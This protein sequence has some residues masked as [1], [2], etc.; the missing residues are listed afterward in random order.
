MML[1]HKEIGDKE[2]KKIINA[3]IDDLFL[4]PFS[5]EKI[6]LHLKKGLRQRK[7]ILHERQIEK[8]LEQMKIKINHSNMTLEATSL[9]VHK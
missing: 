4:K 5:S 3:G 6:L 8:E 1:T 7:L 9:T 2:Y